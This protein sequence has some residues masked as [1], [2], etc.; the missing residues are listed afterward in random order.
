VLDERYRWSPSQ[1]VR[2][3][4]STLEQENPPRLVMGEEGVYVPLLLPIGEEKDRVSSE[5]VE[6]LRKIAD[7]LRPLNAARG[8]GPP[9]S[10]PEE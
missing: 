2:E 10:E 6:Q 5:L 8:L 4:L 1:K 7:L 3:A 9:P